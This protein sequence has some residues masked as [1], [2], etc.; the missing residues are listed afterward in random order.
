MI[1]LSEKKARQT[2]KLVK[3]KIMPAKHGSQRNIKRK[4]LGGLIGGHPAET[5]G[6]SLY[7]AYLI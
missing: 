2:I 4:P 5:A 1:S 6:C 7:F 3:Y